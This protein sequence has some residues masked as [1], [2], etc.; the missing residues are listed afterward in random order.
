MHWHGEDFQSDGSHFLHLIAHSNDLVGLEAL[1][2]QL[3]EYR[4]M[5]RDHKIVNY[6]IIDDL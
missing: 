2:D 1:L 6:C 4:E 3:K 5:S